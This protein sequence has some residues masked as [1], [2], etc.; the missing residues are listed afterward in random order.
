M[1]SLG[2][3]I[4]PYRLII[5]I[6][7][8]IP[9][10][11][12]LSHFVGFKETEN[13]ADDV[14]DAFV[15][16][17]VGFISAAV[18]MYLFGL[19]DSSMSFY[20]VIGKISLQAVTAAIGAMYAQSQLGNSGKNA[21]N[22]SDKEEELSSYWGELFLMF[23]GAIFLAMNPA[24]TEEMYLIA[25]KMSEVQMVLLALGSLA[26]MHAFVYSVG[27][28]GEEEVAAETSFWLVF[29]RFTVVGYAVALLTSFYLLW[30]FGSLDG[31]ALKNMLEVTIV[32]AF[33][34]ALGA[35]AS[36]VIL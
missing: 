5:Y 16:Y 13:I 9:L 25:F 34:S 27:F 11:V 31:L 10:L 20:E 36:R 32:L 15:G 12:G 4:P 21:D 33:P 17:A 6:F 30:T 8:S 22:N 19:I 14:I 1:W 18:L 29:L 3:T 26:V 23:V 2:F 7:L 28:A 35:A 24:A